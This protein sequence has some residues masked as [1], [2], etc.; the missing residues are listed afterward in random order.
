MKIAL[1]TADKFTDYKLLKL[2]LDELK[3]TEIICGNTVGY[4]FAEQYQ[5]ENSEVL[6][7]KGEGKQAQR[8]YDAINKADTVVIFTN[9]TGHW[10]KSRTN[11]A[12]RH[13]LQNNKQLQVYPYKAEVFKISKEDEYIKLDF[14]KRVSDAFNMD[15]I[16]LNEKEVGSLIKK[17]QNMIG[18]NNE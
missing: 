1:I 10:R 7:S 8:A 14:T 11:L 2:K 12:I 17:L 9:G 5:L 6:L 16:Y 13:A 4:E 3:V 18:D 15:G